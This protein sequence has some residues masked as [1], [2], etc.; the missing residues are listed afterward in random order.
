M[1]QDSCTVHLSVLRSLTLFCGAESCQLPLF[2]AVRCANLGTKPWERWGTHPATTRAS[3]WCASAPT[4]RAVRPYIEGMHLQQPL[5]LPVCVNCY[6]CR[7]TGWVSHRKDYCADLLVW[8]LWGRSGKRCIRTL[9][10]RFTL[11][12]SPN[13]LYPLFACYLAANSCYGSSHLLFL[14]PNSRRQSF[15]MQSNSIDMPDT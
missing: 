5:V 7:L 13:I 6:R 12:F 4:M 9:W 8:K 11:M 15:S 3:L 14:L 10:V 2:P 1:W